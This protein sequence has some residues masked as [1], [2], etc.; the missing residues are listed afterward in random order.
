MPLPGGPADKFGNR[1]ES[2][3]TVF[4]LVRII[5]ED[6]DS[7]RIEEPTV[8][9]AEFVVTVGGHWE[10][11]QARSS[12]P[13]GKWSLSS[14]R[15]KGLLLSIFD[16]L[17]ENPNIRFIFVSGSDAPELR[18]LTRRAKDAKDLEEFEAEFVNAQ[19]QKEA[20]TTLKSFWQNAKTTTAY[21]ILQRIE[22]RTMDEQGIKEQVRESLQARFLTKP[23]DVCDALHSIVADSIHKRIDHKQLISALGE[24]GFRLRKLAKP[25]DAPSLIAE[26]TNRYL[27]VTK[28]KLI[29]GSIIPRSSTQTL[30][31]KI[32]ENATGCDCILT[33][34]AGGG[35]TACVIECVEALRKSE[36]PVAVLAFRLD[37]KKL[38]KRLG[39]EES[40]GFVLAKAA[41]AMS[42]EAVLIVDQLDFVSTTSGRSPDFFDVVEELLIE[43]RGWRNKIKIHVVVVCRESDW[44]NDH[45]LRHFLAKEHTHI[46]VTDFSPDE[47]KSV[48]ENG[49]FEIELFTT[50]QLELLRLPQNLSLFLDTSYDP[51]S[52]P[53]FSSTNELF[54]HYWKE[55]RRVV[56]K[57]AAPLPDYWSDVI[58]LMCDE[59]TASQ[60]LSVR[61]EKLDQ[62]PVDYLEQMASE[63]VLSFDG[64][65]YGFGHET[66]FD[67]CFARNFVAKDESLTK[68]L[69]KSEQHLFHRAQV[70]QVLD[71]LREAD[72]KR[73]HKELSALLTDDRIRYH[74]KD[75]AIAWTVAQPS[76]A[77]QD[78]KVLAPWIESELAAVESGNPNPDKFATLVWNKFFSSQHW[79]QISDKKGLIAEWLMSEND[80]LVDKGVNYI[81][82]HL[83]HSGD[84]VAELL[85]P[86]VGRGGGWPQR[87]NNIMQWADYA[88]S[89]R[90]FNLFLKLLDDGTLDDTYN[91]LVTNG[92]F[93]SMFHRLAEARPDWIAEVTAH[94]LLRR[95]S[96]IR[97]TRDNGGTPKWHDLF[98][99]DKSGQ[100][101]IYDSATKFPENFAQHVLPLVLKTT[102][103]TVYKE[104]NPPPRLHAVWSTLSNNDHVSIDN[105]C[106]RALAVALE[107]LAEE[108][109]DSINGILLELQSRDTYM[110][111][112]L[113]LRV[114]TAGASHFANDAV[115]E[116]CDK[117][118][119]FQ[120]GYS[121]SPHWIAIQL[122]KA[123]AP[124]CASDNLDSLEKSILGYSPNYEIDP[125]KRTE[126]I[127][128][129]SSTLGHAPKYEHIPS[130]HKFKERACFSLLSGIP[131]ELR[132]QKAQ[133]R[134][135]ELERKFGT[136][137]PPPQD[138]RA[139]IST[140]IS[141]PIKKSSAEEMKDEEWLKAIKKYDSQ[142]I[143]SW[144]DFEEGGASG[145]AGMLQECVKEE[146][147]RFARL[148][149][150]FPS[151]TNPVYL[152]HVLSGLKETAVA[153]ELKLEVC[154]KAYSTTRD[155]C[156]KA[157]A[158]LLGSIEDE[159]PDDAVQMLNWL[160]T[161]H[162]DP[163]NELSSEKITG[164]TPYYLGRTVEL[165]VSTTRGRAA[166]AIRDLIRR[167]A[168]YIER[169][170]S[171]IKRL[172]K[173]KSLA[174]RERV[175]STVLVIANH[176][177][178]FALEQFLRLIEPRD[179]Q[180]EDDRLLVTQYAKRFIRFLRDRF[181]HLQYV[182]RRILRLGLPEKI[183]PRDSQTEND[184][185]LA[186][187][188]AKRFIKFGLPDHF[189]RLQSVIERM[190]RSELP[191][192]S[193]A[194]ARLASLAVLYN[195]DEAGDLVEEALRR[196]SSQKIGVAQVASGNI[197]YA[198][199]RSW[200]E[201]QLLRLFNDDDSE[202]RQE[203][204]KCFHSLKGQPPQTYEDL[205]IKCCDSLAFKEASHFIFSFLEE[206]PHR[207]P[208]ITYAVCEKYLKRF[209]DGSDGSNVAK[210]ILRTYHQH[211]ND[212]WTS[213]C[214]D[215]IDRMCLER[216]YGIKSGL[217][218]YER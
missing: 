190:L 21:E 124:L 199:Y 152:E 207:L 24:R 141:S 162:S 42:A 127:K 31:T 168:S 146:P 210:L 130:E 54:D 5:R 129:V 151:D 137:E 194:G 67:Y 96:I 13:N 165:R 186:T 20:F 12:H 84:R 139:L 175:S 35:K 142:E 135:A 85:E 117:T 1:Y 125:K 46:P 161:E 53:K 90:F 59:M 126:W 184:R 193:V 209:G 118:W 134:Y 62:F 37:H 171:T 206:S 176:D 167:D 79:F 119:R 213:K 102:D 81:R 65:L 114:Y 218:E 111:N 195:H 140:P 55:K 74:L 205:I 92:T 120:C 112:F 40:P 93:W 19:A 2:W 39:L 76:P 4:Q 51:D 72:R 48:I 104:E 217:D 22:V 10:L 108:K 71:Y 83:N 95:F 182:I 121:N 149:F 188:Y 105:G 26:V 66:F 57:R 178:E 203:A 106:S 17:S 33:G 91:S 179:S 109:S 116:L 16:Q 86:F 64:N 201:Q 8:D 202:V 122:I 89:R 211:Q 212:E 14:L 101:Y 214:L 159:F 136:G 61:K 6:A 44:N 27:E 18:E 183:E 204:T 145:L 77:E 9:K 196:D 23:D 143:F 56:N 113:L 138:S 133:T 34:K 163:E 131:D 82:Y 32:K 155:D 98:S 88:S 197:R 216:I 25:N 160:A 36:N 7:I 28:K 177:W 147:E 78:W 49:G 58:Q 164:S 172:V 45:R 150:R 87:F 115:A 68:L 38:G 50:R 30:L 103:E 110:A 80:H 200:S 192:T 144:D 47:V 153:T 181:K 73:C 11:H 185:L 52:K 29:Q 123:I 170:H 198:E 43:V 99:R 187:Q 157:I 154:R 60:Q 100:K 173:D 3:W 132:S 15:Y 169:F 97:E 69:V 180:T 107:R 189:M 148:S 215:L 156:G 191:E 75:L 41:E 94:W 166:E 158:D 63:G 174:V 128:F 208:G 70:R